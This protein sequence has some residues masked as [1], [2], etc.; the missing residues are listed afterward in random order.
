MIRSTFLRF[1]YQQG[2]Y[3]GEEGPQQTALAPVA[4]GPYST[5]DVSLDAAFDLLPLPL[6]YCS[7][8]IQYSGVPGSVIGEVSSVESKGD[9][10]IDSRLAN[11]RDGWAGSGGHP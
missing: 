2:A 10:V 6:P 8:R 9:L 5:Q 11:E 3:P 4:L 1:R 7:V